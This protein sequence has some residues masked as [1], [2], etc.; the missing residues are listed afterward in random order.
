MKRKALIFLVAATTFL[1]AIGGVAALLSTGSN[2]VEVEPAVRIEQNNADTP[3]MLIASTPEDG[4]KSSSSVS[5]KG[6][7]TQNGNSWGG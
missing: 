4:D 3:E 5:D 1:S 2:S 6:G 7:T